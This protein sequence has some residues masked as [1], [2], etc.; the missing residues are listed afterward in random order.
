MDSETPFQAVGAENPVLGPCSLKGGALPPARVGVVFSLSHLLPR[1]L[2]AFPPTPELAVPTP[3]KPSG[4]QVP[5]PSPSSP[6]EVLAEPVGDETVKAVFLFISSRGPFDSELARR[7]L[8][9]GLVGA[10]V[11]TPHT[12]HF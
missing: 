9:P 1:S 12:Y 5:S 7:P 2:E 10:W 6:Q 11:H 3:P 4:N 8:E